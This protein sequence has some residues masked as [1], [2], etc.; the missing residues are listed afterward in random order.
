MRPRTILTVAIAF[1][2][3]GALGTVGLLAAYGLKL[4]GGADASSRPVWT[5]MAW[6]FQIDQWGT[7]KA[8]HR[9]AGQDAVSGAA[10]NVACAVFIYYSYR[11]GERAS[12]VDF[13]VYY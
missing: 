11:L 8:F 3:G 7:G 1:A 6:P 2:L 12:G 10:I 9:R 13:I 5:E 4:G